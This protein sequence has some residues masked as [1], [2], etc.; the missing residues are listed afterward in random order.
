MSAGRESKSGEPCLLPGIIRVRANNPGPFTGSGTNTYVLGAGDARIVVDPG[1]LDPAHM[2]AILAAAG[3]RPI[4]HILVTHAHRDHVDG[5][6]ALK[7]ATGARTFGYGR[8]PVDGPAPPVPQASPSGGDFVDVDLALDVLVRDGDVIAAPGLE[9]IALHTPGHA[10]DH[11]CFA[12]SRSPVLL[13]G[14]HVMGWSTSVI[15]PPE[16]HM[17]RYL[18][19]LEAL[20]AR[21]ETMYLPGHGEAVEDAQRTVRAY[22]IHRQMREQAVLDAI[23]QG[24]TSIEAVTGVVY[25]GIADNLMNAA[26]LSA[27]AHVELLAEKGQLAIAGPLAA[28]SRLALR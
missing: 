20:L 4:T 17:G 8:R 11:L 28:P 7:T 6:D 10:P 22:L 1:P 14:D 23:R 13:S 25:A 3:S 12:V 2:A 16:G 27:I 26:R 18:A 21:P 5:L 15:A 9:V 19:S 24:A